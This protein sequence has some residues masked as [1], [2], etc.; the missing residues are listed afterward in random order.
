M[1]A[2]EFCNM[3]LAVLYCRAD[4]AKLCLFCDRQVH[5]A[6]TLSLKHCRSRICDNCRAEP[7]TVRCCDEK[8]MLCQECNWELHRYSS[9]SCLH[10]RSPVEGFIGCPSVIELAT[11]FGVDLKAK[12]L[13]NMLEL[14]VPDQS[15]SVFVSSEKYKQELCEQL[16]EIGK[17]DFGR[18]EGDGVEL[19]QGTPP[20]RCGQVG[21]VESLGGENAGNDELLEQQTPC[22]SLVMSPPFVD[23]RDF[24]CSVDEG[25]LIWDS[26]PAHQAA[27]VGVSDFLYV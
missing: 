1:V 18:L 2:C 8:L 16:M 15:C 14:M 23:L 21:N 6:N 20:C 27:Q 25:R 19:G 5:S 17:E 13:V 3:K 26:N 24:N 11:L 12:N 22:V 9:A 7:V 4:S 10:K